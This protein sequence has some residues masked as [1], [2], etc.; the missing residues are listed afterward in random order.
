M[1]DC[2]ANEQPFVRYLLREGIFVSPAK[3]KRNSNWG[4]IFTRGQQ[5]L[6][7]EAS[8]SYGSSDELYCFSSW[9]DSGPTQSSWSL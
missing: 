9:A 1:Q 5:R 8:K 4:V 6:R 7:T 2:I 3:Q